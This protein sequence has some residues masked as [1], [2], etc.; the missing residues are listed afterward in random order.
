MDNWQIVAGLGAVVAA[1]WPQVRDS[2][3]YA[4][5]WLTRP[6]VVVPAVVGPVIAEDEAD[7]PSYFT[8]IVYLDGVRNRLRAVGTYDEPKKQAIDLLTL[9]LGE[10]SDK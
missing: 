4:R 9:A 10:G 8:A 7:V 6:R 5:A 3:A 1:F 2:V